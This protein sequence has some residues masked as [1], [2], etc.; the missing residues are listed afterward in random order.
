MS[1]SATPQD[2]TEDQEL[3]AEYADPTE[4]MEFAPFDPTEVNPPA[5]GTPQGTAEDTEVDFSGPF[6]E[7]VKQDFE[8]L[9]FLG[10][11]SASFSFLGH[12]FVIRTLTSDEL[13]AAGMITKDYENTIAANRAY[14]TAMVALSI[15]TV[16]GKGLPIPIG[17]NDNDYAWAYERFN[18][19][20]ARWFPF[21]VDYVYDRCLVLEDR[22]RTV[23]ME[24]A[25]KSQGRTES[26][27][28]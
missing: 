21:V 25:K 23:L 9:M 16:D 14:A 28:G 26:I 1:D 22:A 7:R 13:I 6:N 19:I 11:L 18:F 27:P 4:G 10:A 17:S 15:Q 8:G 24:M 12:R 5:N 3:A 2:V 20:K